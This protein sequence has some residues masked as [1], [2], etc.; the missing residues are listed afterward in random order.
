MKNKGILYGLVAYTAWGLLPIYWKLLHNVPAVELIGHR[1][2]W[3]FAVLAVWIT[4]PRGWRA[5]RGEPF[6]QE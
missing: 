3:S 6:L 2:A 5:M 1:I 4:V